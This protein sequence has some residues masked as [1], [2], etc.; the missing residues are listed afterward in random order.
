LPDVLAHRDPDAHAAQHNRPR[1]GAWLEHALLI[2]HAVIRQLDLVARGGDLATFQ[3]QIGIVQPAVV[4]PW[5]ADQHGR[6]TVSGFPRERLDGGTAGGLEGRLEHEV[7]GRIA[8]DEQLG[9][10]DQ[11][12]ALPGRGRTRPAHLFGIAGHIA[13]GR[14]E[15]RERDRETVG[16]AGVHSKDVARRLACRNAVRSGPAIRRAQAAR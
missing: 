13:D 16:G 14:I 11:I 9:E 10:N 15:L 4:D 1:Q 2:E 8:G 3:Q 12:G 7:L 5:R 6:P